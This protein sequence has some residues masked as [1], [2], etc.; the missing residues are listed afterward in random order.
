M[1]LIGLLLRLL[2]GTA[3]AEI[4]VARKVIF[5]GSLERLS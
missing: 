5:Q 3:Q 2:K 1:F 4:R